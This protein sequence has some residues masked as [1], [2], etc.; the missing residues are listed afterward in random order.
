MGYERER[1][2]DGRY[3]IWLDQ[4]TVDKLKAAR[5][6]ARAISETVIRLAVG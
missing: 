2:A 6:P 3:F 4:R 5:Q 1:T